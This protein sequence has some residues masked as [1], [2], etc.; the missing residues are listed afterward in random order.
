MR[1]GP[2]IVSDEEERVIGVPTAQ[3]TSNMPVLGATSAEPT[4]LRG[5]LIAAVAIVLLSLPRV[6]RC[7]DL[8]KSPK[9]APTL[10]RAS[11]RG[12]VRASFM[13]SEKR[14][15][16]L[17]HSLFSFFFF[18]LSLSPS[19]SVFPFTHFNFCQYLTICVA[20]VPGRAQ[21]SPQSPFDESKGR[22]RQLKNF[23]GDIP[24]R[25]SRVFYGEI[26]L[27]A[28]MSAWLCISII[29]RESINTNFWIFYLRQFLSNDYQCGL[30]FESKYLIWDKFQVMTTTK[31]L[32][33]DLIS[34]VYIVLEF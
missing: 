24:R 1:S 9:C 33:T 14:R 30:K 34:N 10:G 15:L 11:S 31:D 32:N 27:G 19:F 21:P 17:S 2:R 12:V 26:I 18:P 7:T 16:H 25:Q 3:V 6:C 13:T 20:V 23:K 29:S 8:G 4:P 22:V 28:N 5:L